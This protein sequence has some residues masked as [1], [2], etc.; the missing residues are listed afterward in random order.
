MQNTVKLVDVAYNYNSELCATLTNS[1]KAVRCE[2]VLYLDFVNYAAM[3]A[4]YEEWCELAD[5]G[6]DGYFYVAA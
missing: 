5:A 3:C 1:V 6:E 4:V 2:D